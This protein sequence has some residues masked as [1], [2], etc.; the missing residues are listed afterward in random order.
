MKIHFPKIHLI[1]LFFTLNLWAQLPVFNLQLTAT[2]ETCTGN[3]T[4]TFATSNTAAG[5]SMLYAVYLL[6]NTA[7][8]LTTTSEPTLGGLT[9]GNYRVVAT[10]T[11]GSASNVQQ[12]EATITTTIAPLAYVL[13][14]N[15]VCL[16]GTIVVT[17]TSGNAVFYEILS[18]P[19][20]RPQQPSNVFT[21]LPGGTYTI[22]VTDACNDA[23]V[24]TFTLI[25]P[26]AD[27]A[28]SGVFAPEC[29]LIDCHTV[30]LSTT[31]AAGSG[32]SINY[33][34]QVAYTVHPPS[35]GAAIIVSQTVSEG[36]PDSQEMLH[37]LP[38]FGGQP[39]LVDVTITDACG[40]VIVKNGNW[41]DAHLEVILQSGGEICDRNIKIEACHFLPPFTVSFLSAPPGFNPALFNANHPGPFG[42]TP[43]VYA[44]YGP[45]EMPFGIYTVQITDGCGS[46]AQSTIE[47]TEDPEPL[48]TAFPAGCGLGEVQ[49]PATGVLVGS[50][51]ITAAPPA[52]QPALPHDVSF[53]I[54][55]GEFEIKDLPG[56]T[57]T[58]VVTSLC[59]GTYEYEIT[60]PPSG[61]LPVLSSYIRGC[62]QGYGSIMLSIQNADVVAASITGAPAAFEP[63][64]PLDISSNI[65]EGRV[66]MNSLPQGIYTFSV[67]DEC[68]TTRIVMLDI[69]GYDIS[70]DTVQINE[71]CGSFDIAL[72]YTVN[73]PA[74]HEYFLQRFNPVSGHWE[75]PLTGAHYLEGTQPSVQNSYPLI[76]HFVNINIASVGKFRVLKVHK[77]YGNGTTD[78]E[79]CVIPIKEFDFT[80]G[81]KITDAYALACA[82]GPGQILIIAQGM[83]PLRYYITS[84]DGQAFYLDNGTSNV[85]SGLQPGIYNFQVRDTC[86]N[87]VNRLFDFGTIPPPQ[88]VQSILCDGQ[89]GQLAVPN[90]SFLNYQWWNANNPSLILS[91]SN[92][93]NFAPFASAVH[94]GTYVVRIYSNDPGVCS[95]QTV[96]YTISASGVNPQAGEGSEVWLCGSSGSVDLFDYLSGNYNPGGMWNETTS[97]GMQIGHSWLPVGIPNG[98]YTFMYTVNGLCSTSDT[99]TVTIH[100]N[101]ETPTPLAWV[102][103]VICSLG[104]IELQATTIANATYQWTGP[105]GFS[106]QVQN[107]VIN[108]ATAVNSGMYSV[109]A[110]V[111]HCTS[112]ATTVE[113]IVNPSPDFRLVAGCNGNQY[114]I[115]VVANDPLLNPAGW[116]YHWSGPENYTYSNNPALIS[117]G[118][119]GTYTVSITNAEGCT[120]VQHI[121]V[122]GT[123]CSVP[124]GISPNGDGKNDAF[125]LTGFDVLEFKIFNRYGRMVFEQ[126]DYTNQW[127]GQ[128]FNG[129]LLPDA[130]Y[131]YYIKRKTGEEQT[132]WVYVTR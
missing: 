72:D 84:K 55:G 90:V 78:S 105:N 113:V 56:G 30:M 67:V 31:I 88:I 13:S 97:S 98:A 59:G 28:I 124:G 81:P 116:E 83:A 102:N 25:N 53:L 68:G 40:N 24:Q 66:Y 8:P 32:S 100:L 125:D 82:G 48:Y 95:D 54:S 14:G 117:G 34:L 110:T 94:S 38:Y 42:S 118:Q 35:G 7:T 121:E 69:P 18:G 65:A 120:V 112:A 127:Y 9:A 128:D 114:Q 103:P 44:Q 33:P 111:G 73:E 108:N 39:Y 104:T 101:P 64:L 77:K 10:Q 51:I 50:V 60:I 23:L 74:P 12:Q 19:V 109:M 91:N 75:H 52:Y 29:T 107:P 21:G 71:H 96:T 36:A 57:Y 26:N 61:Q 17:P 79:L 4:L 1:F 132:G 11:L 16:N 47:L 15:I 89:N 99:A 93:L 85:F 20:V 22:R 58:F 27:Y 130:T 122:F 43:I 126:D 63:S 87:I 6:P 129:N 131:Y 2:N 49:I 3:G 37:P 115:A 80:G 41:V 106:S 119:N 92:V 123:L 70:E 5:A 45:G 76:N 62:V 46:I 86:Q